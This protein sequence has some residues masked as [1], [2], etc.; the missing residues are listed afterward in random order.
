MA[1]AW[2]GKWL[3]DTQNGNAQ[4]LALVSIEDEKTTSRRTGF[5]RVCVKNCQLEVGGMNAL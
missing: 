1:L 4:G 3:P 5:D 2:Y